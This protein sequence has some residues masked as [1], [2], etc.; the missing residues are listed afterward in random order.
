MRS[1]S[2]VF[3]Q[4]TMAD[5][6]LQTSQT[7]WVWTDGVWG[8][9]QAVPPLLHPGSVS[10]QGHLGSSPFFPPLFEAQ[11]VKVAIRATKP[12]GSMLIP[13]PFITGAPLDV[14]VDKQMFSPF[15]KS[16]ETSHTGTAG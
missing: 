16:C 12:A 8:Q 2:R 14:C 4:A 1:A 15:S 3:P 9:A 6:P 10:P 11:S 5:A 13:L 7:C